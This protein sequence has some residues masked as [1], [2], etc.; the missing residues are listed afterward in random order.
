MLKTENYTIPGA[1]GRLM[2]ADLTFDD[3][4]PAAPLII[5]VHG[6]KG[7]KDW[8][9]HHLM[10]K[11]FAEA[12]YRYLK[13]NF[14]HNGVTPEYPLDFVD[15]IAFSENTFTI[16]L[17]DLKHVLDFVASGAAVPATTSVTLLGHSMGGGISIIKAAEDARVKNLI[18][19]GSV[20]DFKNL[21]PEAVEQQWRL[22]GV[23]HFPNQRTGQEMPVKSTFL[24]DVDHNPARL[25]ILRRAAEVT[26]PWLICHGT[27]DETVGLE[28]AHRLKVANPHAELVVFEGVDHVFGGT[29]PYLENTLPGPLLELCNHAVKFLKKHPF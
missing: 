22:A 24:N 14:S 5:F 4:N 10:A 29:H 26:Q 17:E 3:Q 11:Y 19:M 6:F 16:E 8:G 23:M 15:L 1:K 12:G 7:F 25:N 18:T 9:S 21:W 20:A 2:T 13:F 27:A 28:H